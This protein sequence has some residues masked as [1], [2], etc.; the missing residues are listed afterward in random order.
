MNRRMPRPTSPDKGAAVGLVVEDLMGSG[1]SP[2]FSVPGA[3]TLC[4]Q[5]FGD[6]LGADILQKVAS[7]RP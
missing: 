3:E 1:V 7:L 6:F 2:G 4:I 5:R